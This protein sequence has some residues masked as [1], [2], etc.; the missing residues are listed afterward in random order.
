MMAKSFE[1]TKDLLEKLQ[2]A[3]LEMLIEVDRICRKNNINY[4]IMY[5]TLLEAVRNGEFIPYDDLC[6]LEFEGHKFL[7]TK[8]FKEQLM[9][10]YGK[11]YMKMQSK[12]E[13]YPHHD[14]DEI[15]F[16]NIFD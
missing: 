5:G 8:Y 9:I 11:D 16:G 13:R 3:E 2:K 1:I 14:A 12:E 4:S 10:S 7:A 6:E 15:S